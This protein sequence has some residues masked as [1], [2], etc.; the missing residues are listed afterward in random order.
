MKLTELTQDKLNDI[1]KQYHKIAFPRRKNDVLPS[2]KVDDILGSWE[3]GYRFGISGHYLTYFHWQTIKD[4]IFF[5][6]DE[7]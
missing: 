2:I 7:F 3:G 4:Y 5:T 1:V 6:V